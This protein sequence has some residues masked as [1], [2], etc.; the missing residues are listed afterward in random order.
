MVVGLIE[1]VVKVVWYF[2]LGLILCDLVGCVD[3]F[4]IFMQMPNCG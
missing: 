1:F 4:W 2:M 3:Y